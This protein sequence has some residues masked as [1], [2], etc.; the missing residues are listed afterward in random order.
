MLQVIDRGRSLDE[1]FNGDWFRA[2]PASRRDL[3]LCR[4]LAFGLCRWYF[5]LRPLLEQRMQKPLRKRDRDV[6]IILLI[7]LYQLLVLQT[8]AH[9]AVNES[10]KLCQAQKKKWAS[11][12]VNALLRG[13]L[14]EQLALDEDAC[15]QA[16]PEWMRARL[17]QDWNER[18]A[19]I[20]R[21][22]NQRPPMTRIDTARVDVE[23]WLQQLE[24]TGASAS[25][26]PHVDS[27]VV[28]DAPCD[29]TQLP[30]FDEGRVSVQDASAQLAACLLPCDPGAHVLDACAAPGGKTLHL[31]QRYPRIALDALDSS[32]DRLER[33]QQN[34]QRGAL[35]AC[36]LTGDEA[37]PAEW[38][39]GRF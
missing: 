34:L 29:V 18:S 1:I 3:G 2:L 32:A 5:V 13:V 31:L 6:E 10:V 24:A 26:H 33:L 22:L 7:G 20:L 16:F 4:E 12:L 23:T 14:R 30:G 9:A 37:R 36:V 21:A 25:R 8:G 17:E 38:W 19:G 15:L 27:A 35:V 28:L 39:D 11:G